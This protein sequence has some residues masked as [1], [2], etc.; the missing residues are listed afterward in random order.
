METEQVLQ[1]S[2]CLYTAFFHLFL[3]VDL[4]SP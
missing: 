4:N 2:Q 3:Y 1:L